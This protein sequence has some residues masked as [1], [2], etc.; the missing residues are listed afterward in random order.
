MT[1]VSSIKFSPQGTAFGN[2][3]YE[4]AT[5]LSRPHR[6][7]W[8]DIWFQS[9]HAQSILS[10]SL[11]TFRLQYIFASFLVKLLSEIDVL[12]YN[13]SGNV[14]QLNHRFNCTVNVIR[15][16]IL[17]DSAA[18][19]YNHIIE[20]IV[21]TNWYV[22]ICHK[23]PGIDNN[24]YYTL[25]Q[26]IRFHSTFQNSDFVVWV[27]FMITLHSN[28]TLK[29]KY[30]D[31]GCSHLMLLSTFY[32]RLHLMYNIL[33]TEWTNVLKPRIICYYSRICCRS[34]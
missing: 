8:D 22:E 9:R 1:F 14:S 6:I 13:T 12:V 4:I 26:P 23:T 34:N 10:W 33:N 24:I 11:K 5:M 3:F 31:H 17:R 21:V 30:G 15:S 18:V 2:V 7:T 32:W 19:T 20:L 28:V 29:T 25:V 27:T 16:T